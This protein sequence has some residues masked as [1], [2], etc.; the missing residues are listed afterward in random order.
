MIDRKQ[1]PVV[2][3]VS[4]LRCKGVMVETV[5]E[6]VE[7]MRSR[8]YSLYCAGFAGGIPTALIGSKSQADW[9]EL[10]A[11]LRALKLIR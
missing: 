7:K 5:I 8:R 3:D 9:V 10:R 2:K 4:C 1:F 6:A 11:K